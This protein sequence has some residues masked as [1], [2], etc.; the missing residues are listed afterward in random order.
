MV[1]GPYTNCVTRPSSSVWRVNRSQRSPRFRVEVARNFPVILKERAYFPIAPVAEAAGERGRLPA[2]DA[3]INARRLRVRTVC[4]KKQLIEEVV[5]RTR[6][7]EFAVLDITAKV[8]SGFQIVFPVR[9]GNQVGIFV[10][11]LV[12]GLRISV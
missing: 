12:E 3:G 10:N 11:V 4:R 2:Q 8:H 7:V 6:D 9:N 5:R 1:P